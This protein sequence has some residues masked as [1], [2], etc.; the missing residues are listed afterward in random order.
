MPTIRHYRELICWQLATEL[1]DRIIGITDRPQVRRR[2]KFCD[3]V[4]KSTRS[5]PANIAEG[6]D[7]TNR[8]F[9]AYL[10][11]ALGSLRETETHLDEA[12]R[13]RFVSA[14]ECADL[15]TLA[16]RSA[17][18]ANELKHYLERRIRGEQPPT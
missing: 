17:K 11:I 9:V 5:A 10:D 6:F 4:D 14:T 15:K 18:A 8:Q 13:R 7:R 16:K 3:Q 1:R 12:L 2:H